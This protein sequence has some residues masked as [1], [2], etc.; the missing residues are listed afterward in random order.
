M[1]LENKDGK[2]FQYT[3]T[4]EKNHDKIESLQKEFQILKHL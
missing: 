3:T 1:N 4:V 2:C